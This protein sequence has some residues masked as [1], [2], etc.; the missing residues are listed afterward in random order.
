MRTTYEVR[1]ASSVVCMCLSPPLRHYTLGGGHGGL[2]RFRVNL[3]YIVER[4]L[5]SVVE[6][7]PIEHRHVE[8]TGLQN[9]STCTAHP[10]VEKER[11][12]LPIS[13]IAF[14]HSV[15]ALLYLHQCKYSNKQHEEVI[16][17]SKSY[18][19][20]SLSY[21]GAFLHF[22]EMYLEAVV[23]GEGVGGAADS[24]RQ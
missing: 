21:N 1:V 10:S 17:S 2:R 6:F 13:A 11:V 5:S 24:P 7:V 9:S 8:Q 20:L 23:R 18:P 19:T 12:P 4:L 15:I 16:F 22:C 14:I 3:Y